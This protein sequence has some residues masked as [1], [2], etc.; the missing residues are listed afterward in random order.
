MTVRDRQ[1]DANHHGGRCKARVEAPLGGDGWREMCE[2][3]R[4]L[5]PDK[6]NTA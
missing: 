6:H 1:G 2:E 5:Q 4:G 3:G